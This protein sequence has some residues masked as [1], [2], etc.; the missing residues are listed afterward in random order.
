[1]LPF[2]PPPIEHRFICLVDRGRRLNADGGIARDRVD[3][4]RVGRDHRSN[5]VARGSPYG[6]CRGLGR[7]RTN[8]G[9][10]RDIQH[11]GEI[12]NLTGIDPVRVFDDSG[13]ETVDLGPEQRIIEIHLGDGPQGLTAD[14]CV[15]RWELSLE[16]SGRLRGVL[17]LH[18]LSRILRRQDSPHERF[19]WRRHSDDIHAARR[20][21][22][23][24]VRPVR[25]AAARSQANHCRVPAPRGKL[26]RALRALLVLGL[27]H[28]S[29][30]HL[31]CEPNLATGRRCPHP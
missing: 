13:V 10:L 24:P 19:L 17:L 12:E 25:S 7:I 5:R 29:V 1:M 9:A 11:L 31:S 3:H 27:R 14:Y 8:A 21:G 6:V 28:E 4:R 15:T 20:V 22:R 18:R 2:G 16:G 23:R 26:L 30:G